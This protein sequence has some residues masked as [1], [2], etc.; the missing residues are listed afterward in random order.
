MWHT[1][2][3][4]IGEAYYVRFYYSL[5][6][7]ISHPS[8]LLSFVNPKSRIATSEAQSIDPVRQQLIHLQYSIV[9]IDG[10]DFLIF[11]FYD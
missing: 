6:V 7:L 10:N 11:F 9:N 4:R 2:K 5:S 3:A 1:S 8:I